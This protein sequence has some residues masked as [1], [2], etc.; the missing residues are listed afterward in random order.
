MEMNSPNKED[1]A[2]NS[3]GVLRFWLVRHG[4]TQWNTQHR[5]CGHSDVPLS[6]AG[7]AQASWLAAQMCPRPLQAIYSSDLARA[8]E[9]AD[10]IA[11]KH[12]PPVVV[13][14]S[15]AWREI[16]FGAWEGLTYS[17]IASTFPDQLDFFTDPEHY[18]PPGGEALADVLRRV[19][20]ALTEIMMHCAP[21]HEGDIVIV[22]HGGTL[23][24]LLCA[25]LGISLS[26]QWQLRLDPGSLSAVDLSLDEH[27]SLVAT[28]A[29]LNWQ[30]SPTRN[31]ISLPTAYGAQVSQI[32]SALPGYAE[33]RS[34]HDD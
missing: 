8:R 9:T 20:P 27:G 34:E 12:V 1:S 11:S 28:L 3:Q 31:T 22:S 15:T 21:Y 4:L 6:V 10:I 19:Q 7:R 32:P 30:H 17:E 29:L 25:L 13:T 18:A 14:V 23:R 33:V 2:E 26:Y 16:A 5:Y 24:G